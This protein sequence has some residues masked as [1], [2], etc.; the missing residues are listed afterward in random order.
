MKHFQF[1]LWTFSL[2]CP[3]ETF[4][5]SVDWTCVHRVS[6]CCCVSQMSCLGHTSSHKSRVTLTS[7]IATGE[8]DT[9]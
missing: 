8:S 5:V 1:S 2:T 4:R 3:Y 7:L 6:V 9:L